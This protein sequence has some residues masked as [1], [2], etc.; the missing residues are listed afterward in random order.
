MATAIG[1]LKMPFDDIAR[2]IN[3]S[4]RYNSGPR[5]YTSGDAIQNLSDFAGDELGALKDDPA[6]RVMDDI[7]ATADLQGADQQAREARERAGRSVDVSQDIFDRR[8]E[9][10][11][12]SDRQKRAAAQ[13]FSLNREVA[14]A[15]ASY[16]SRKAANARSR[17]ASNAIGF[18]WD[19]SA[20]GQQLA[21]LSGLAN[22]EGQRKVREAQERAAKKAR[23]SALIGKIIGTAAAIFSS[24]KDFKSAT[25][26]N[27]QLL[28]R[29]K[30]VRVDK[31]KYHNGD[32]SHIGPY[33]EEF[34]EAFGVG[35]NHKKY[36]NVVDVLGV[37][38]GAVKE[39]NEK[40]EA[41]NV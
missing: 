24:S 9:G 2:Y 41:R 27:P 18:G 14:K 25:E 36:L 8:M 31:W 5:S 23:K 26:K 10:M 4:G 33:A 3:L 16:A 20:F 28:D 35:E 39:L 11:D 6:T 17:V 12:L 38:L 15:G 7:R 19:L 29:L 21:S 1:D 34:N 13:T 37:T 32:R 40:V 22:A 30:K